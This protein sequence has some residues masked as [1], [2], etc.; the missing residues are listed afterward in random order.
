MEPPGTQAGKDVVPGP[1]S[2]VRREAIAEYDLPAVPRDAQGDH[3][4][5]LLDP[6]RVVVA[7]PH[8]DVGPV[9]EDD[10]AVRDDPR[11][12]GYRVAEDP[13]HGLPHGLP[14]QGDAEVVHDLVDDLPLRQAADVQPLDQLADVPRRPLVWRGDPRPEPADP[15]PRDPEREGSVGGVDHPAVVSVPEVPVPGVGRVREE[16]A[17]LV[18]HEVVEDLLGLRPD[19]AVPLAEDRLPDLLYAH[20]VHQ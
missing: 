6:A 20:A 4:A 14:R 18:L 19:E 9:E 8:G 2:L 10:R 5:F 1:G 3:D 11:A 13:V 16:V 17:D 12:E 7:P 15:V